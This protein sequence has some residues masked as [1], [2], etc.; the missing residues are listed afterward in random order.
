MDEG[1]AGGLL[2][3]PEGVVNG[4]TVAEGEAGGLLR[5]PEGVANGLENTVGTSVGGITGVVVGTGAPE[6]CFFIE[7]KLKKK[8]NPTKP[9]RITISNKINTGN[10]FF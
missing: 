9:I 5:I 1:E 3:I 10:F 2:R 6:S 8:N 4:S 7:A